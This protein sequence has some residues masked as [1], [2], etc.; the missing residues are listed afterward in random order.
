MKNRLKTVF[1][2]TPD[3]AVPGLEAL[4]GS[5]HEVGYVVT[6]PDKARDRGKKVQFT[7]VKEKAI[8][9]GIQ[10]LQPEKIKGNDEFLNVLKEYDPDLIVV[11]A[12][13]KLLPPEIIHLPRLGCINIHASLLPR[14]RGA[15]PMQRAIMAGDE[16]TGITL[17]YMEEGLDTGDMI[18]K[19]STP[20]L[21]KTAAELH[22]EMAELGGELLSEQ[23]P[24][25]E[26]GNIIREKQDDSLATY[27]EMIFKKD[28]EINFSKTPAEI[29]RLIRGM[30]S[31]PGAYSCYKGQLMK[32]W[33][34]E[35]SNKV[36]GEPYG[37]IVE[38]S[39][40]GIEVS[41]GGSI[42]IITVIQMPGK[43]R[44]TVADY[45]KGNKIEI[46]EI[47]KKAD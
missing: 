14:W 15:A 20:I 12:Y 25:L 21:K 42:L 2:G 40:N 6:Q 9:L 45:L 8:Q 1:M 46:G 22:D 35:I 24:N 7:P 5:G 30:D 11:A 38:V 43:K 36:C 19:K 31:W 29:E 27:A 13:G 47:L 4:Y 10:V 28:G 44:V 18:A 41:A 37:T 34:A 33:K 23:L 39:D 3:F 32:I 16:N 17:M 26:S